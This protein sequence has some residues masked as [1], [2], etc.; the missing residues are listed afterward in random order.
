MHKHTL[1]TLAFSVLSSLS[2]QGQQP[3]NP[4]PAHCQVALQAPNFLEVNLDDDNSSEYW[5][6]DEVDFANDDNDLKA[7]SFTFSVD[8]QYTG[9]IKVTFEE[10]GE[11]VDSIGWKDMKKHVVHNLEWDILN[12]QLVNPPAIFYLEGKQASSDWQDKVKLKI[13]LSGSGKD[14]PCGAEDTKKFNVVE[15]DLDIDTD[16]SNAE[17]DP[18]RSAWEDN[19]E[20]AVVSPTG[21]P[22]I[23]KLLFANNGFGDGVPDWADGFDSNSSSSEDSAMP[24]VKFVPLK[25]ERKTPYTDQA[26]VTFICNDSDPASVAAYPNSTLFPDHQFRYSKPSGK[27]IRIWKKNNDG[28]MRDKAPIP[29]GDY[30]PA[31]TAIPWSDLASGTLADLWI[32]AVSPSGGIC[33]IEIQAKMEEQ[34]A[35][36]LD[37]VL[38]TSL[39]LNVEPINLELANS[40]TLFPVNPAGL[41]VGNA[42]T[43]KIETR[44][45]NFPN[46]RI[47]W[48]P[49]G[50]SGSFV[51]NKGKEV[52][53]TPSSSGSGSLLVLVSGRY[54]YPYPT[55]SVQ[56]FSSMS[57]VNLFARTAKD[58]S[59]RLCISE[60]D[61]RAAVA[62]ANEILKQGGMEFVFAGWGEIS[63]GYETIDDEDEAE[64]LY[65]E[66]R[67]TNGVEVYFVDA[68]YNGNLGVNYLDRGCIVAAGSGDMNLITKTVAH[69]ISHECGLDDIYVQKKFPLPSGPTED[70]MRWKALAA[71]SVSDWPGNNSLLID[72][73]F[74]KRDRGSVGRSYA[75]RQEDLIVR[76]LMVGSANILSDEIDIASGRVY[77]VAGGYTGNPLRKDWAK[78]GL[79]DMSRTPAHGH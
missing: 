49:S 16:N 73:A 41:I 38:A 30:V 3:Q 62:K 39:E 72:P 27:L 59:G 65:N 18:D 53:F 51:N 78:V 54:L 79:S 21:T 13:V 32:E 15:T 24:G 56:S 71:W 22:Y 61:A 1:T 19:R 35:I 9:T 17:N 2:L 14:G 66:M 12:G 6:K 40:T 43:F 26:T 57:Y 55:F 60:A 20:A 50:I 23:G 34:G 63:G 29:Q 46:D 75:T 4:T 45:A 52:V 47:T 37:K 10:N 31:N 28:S 68:F 25:L 5:D 58:S 77:G 44:P 48:V 7:C 8:N 70:I 74:Y 42:A 69:E 11:L 33:D 67:S 64:D 36:A 76:L